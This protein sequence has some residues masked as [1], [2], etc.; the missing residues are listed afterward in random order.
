MR[1]SRVPYIDRLEISRFRDGQ[2][3]S[4][5]LA[6][7]ASAGGLPPCAP[8]GSLILTVSKSQGFE[9]VKVG[10]FC[11]Q[12]VPLPVGYRHAPQQGALY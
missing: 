4:F 3:G 8:A 12:T 11:L 2:S 10:A 9:T 6:N 1:P 5:L 7:R